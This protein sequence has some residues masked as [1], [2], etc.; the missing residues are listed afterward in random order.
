VSE[1]DAGLQAASRALA[2]VHT[3]RQTVGQMQRDL[4]RLKD[5]VESR[6]AQEKDV[7]TRL[8]A[9]E[10][11]VS[12]MPATAAAPAAAPKKVA[13]R[14]RTVVLKGTQESAEPRAPG[15]I[16]TV[17]EAPVASGPPVPLQTSPRTI[18]T[19][20]I[21]GATVAFGEAVVTP[22]PRRTREPVFAVQLAAG[23]SLAALKEG[24]E[25]LVEKHGSPL[26]SLQPRYVAPK[27]EGGPYRLVAGPLPSREQADKVCADMGVGRNQCF[28]T[29]FAGEPL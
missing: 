1:P 16:V 14:H 10:D 26:A 18:E 19:G 6:E 20:S 11:R 22:T 12:S 23:P 24:W 4:G 29:V 3:V 13:E 21:P 15:H 28:S 7:A 5:T 25:R 9:L 8:T 27:T 2:E 17:T